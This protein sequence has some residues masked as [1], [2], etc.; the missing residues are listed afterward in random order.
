[1]EDAW[2]QP[3]PEGAAEVALCCGGAHCDMEPDEHVLLLSTRTIIR[4]VGPLLVISSQMRVLHSRLARVYVEEAGVVEGAIFDCISL[5][6]AD[7]PLLMC[8]S[9]A[10]RDSGADVRSKIGAYELADLLTR[11]QQ[12]SHDTIERSME[13][14][15]FP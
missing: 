7:L 5:A 4:N 10:L 8:Q 2:N 11:A 12:D 3:E 1:M 14:Y 15:P 9:C 13:E 6:A